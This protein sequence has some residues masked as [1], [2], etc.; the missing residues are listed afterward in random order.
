MSW[1]DCFKSKIYAAPFQFQ[2]KK[3][4][5]SSNQGSNVIHCLVK[6]WQLLSFSCLP[7]HILANVLLAIFLSK[8]GHR[9]L[10][11]LMGQNKNYLFQ[12]IVPI[13]VVF[14][15]LPMNGIYSALLWFPCKTSRFSNV[16]KLR[17]VQMKVI[18]VKT[19]P[20]ISYFRMQNVDSVSYECIVALVALVVASKWR[21]SLSQA[22]S[23]RKG[24]EVAGAALTYSLS[25]LFG[26]KL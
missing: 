21:S 5:W 19:G 11:Q 17:L 7:I 2:W 20:L 3:V 22:C 12:T 26:Q 6:I 8:T 14:A 23:L 9:V 24:T 1:F 25:F 16:W 4:D 15:Y 18:Q 10:V 13:F